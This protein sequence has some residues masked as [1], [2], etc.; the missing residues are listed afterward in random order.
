[1][2]NNHL[3]F[4]IAKTRF[5]NSTELQMKQPKLGKI[6]WL[7]AILYRLEH[8]NVYKHF[9]FMSSVEEDSETL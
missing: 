5:L 8:A 9:M 4:P 3:F 7:E 2:P 6:L 1:M